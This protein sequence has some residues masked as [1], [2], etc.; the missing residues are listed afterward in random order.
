MI[1]TVLFFA[2]DYQS[3][4]FPLLTSTKYKSVCIVLNRKEKEVALANGG[5]DVICFEDEFDLLDSDISLDAYLKYSF[6]CD[7]N[8]VGLT[9]TEREIILKKSILFCSNV[10]EKHNPQ[11]VVNEAVAIEMAEVLAIEAKKKNVKYISW[12]SF[13]KVNTFYWQTS[14]FHN[15]LKN[16]LDDIIPTEESLAEAKIFIEGVKQGVERP[17]YVK[18]S[19]SRYSFLNFVKNI[20]GILVELR[21]LLKLNKVKRR[22]FYGT[23]I[24]LNLWNIKLYLLS[25]FCSSN[26]YDNIDNYTDRELIFY[27]LHYEPEAVLFYMAYFCDNQVSVI[28]N[29]LKCLNQNQILVIKEHP[30]QLGVLLEKR[31]AKIK[32]RYPNL[33][34]IKGEEVTVKVMDKCAVVVTLGSTAGFEALALGKKL[35]VL[36]RVF[37]DNFEGV[38]KCNSFEEVYDLFRGNVAFNTSSNFDLFVAKM[39]EYVNEGNPFP[40]E[41]LYDDKNIYSIVR[42]IEYELV[43]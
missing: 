24:S 36:G 30:Q 43:K 22:A 16:A 32:D 41:Q 5:K 23:I 42:A 37:Y 7:R 31:F 19:N 40:H 25:L 2:R 28:E 4:L 12:M 20:W 27:P 18:K 35:V 1:P 14:P 26:K 6:G 11:L 15:S 21:L 8:Y 34:F 3:K 29:T 33:I 38:N 17:F 39:L 9:L 13:S 10:L